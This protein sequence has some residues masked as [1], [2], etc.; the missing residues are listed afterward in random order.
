MKEVDQVIIRTKLTPPVSQ[1]RK[2]VRRHR[3]SPLLSTSDIPR[4]IIVT[5]PAGYGKTSLMYQWFSACRERDT[6]VGWL[7]ADSQDNNA[8]RFLRHLIACLKNNEEKFGDGAMRYLD[9]ARHPDIKHPAGQLIN[10]LAEDDR[11]AFL[12]ID[13][14]HLIENREVDGFLDYLLKLAPPNL[15]LI[16]SSRLVPDLSLPELRLSGELLELDAR[17]LQFD[18]S[19]TFSF[20]DLIN[21]RKLSSSEVELLHERSEGWVAGLQLAAA[22]LANN[23]GKEELGVA[24]NGTLRDIADYLAKAVLQNQNDDVRDFLLRTSLLERFNADLCTFVTGNADSQNIIEWLEQSHLFV[25]PLD[26][27]RTWYRYHH[28]FQDFLQATLK[29]GLPSEIVAL[30][31]RAAS[32][33][34]EHGLGA[35]AVDYALLTGDIQQAAAMAERHAASQILAGYLP[36]TA[37]WLLQLPDVL[38]QKNPMLLSQVTLC[39]WHIFQQEEASQLLSHFEHHLDSFGGALEDHRLKELRNEVRLHRGGI[40]VCASHA[41]ENVL[42]FLD[43]VD[44]SL[45]SG[46]M[47]AV[48]YNIR[49]IALGENNRFSEAL[50]CFRKAARIH[51]TTG[52]PLGVACSYYLEALM[53]LEC[54]NL[55]NIQDMLHQIKKETVFNSQA[56]NYINPSMLESIEGILHYERGDSGKARELLEANLELTKEVGHLKMVS[57]ARTTYA[58][59]LNRQG[60]L[61]GA[62]KELEQLAEI[63]RRNEPGS[64]RAIILAD[65]ERIKLALLNNNPAQAQYIADKYDLALDGPPPEL[66]NHWD[67][68]SCLKALA[69]C[70]AQLVRN[71]PEKAHDLLRRI[72]LFAREVGRTWRYLEARLLEA[73]ALDMLGR[74]FEAADILKP[75]LQIASTDK[76]VNVIRDEGSRVADLIRKLQEQNELIG[77][78]PAFLARILADTSPGPQAVPDG[79]D[80]LEAALRPSDFSEKERIILEQVALGKSNAMIAKRLDLTAHAI[81]WHLGNIFNKLQVRNRAAA[82]SAAKAIRL[83]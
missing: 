13:D 83:I 30:Y 61:P 67:R 51:R 53:H 15:H 28:L 6:R 31:R 32:W 9:A 20:L 65:Y 36:E 10:E 74:D 73:V 45:L 49:G 78:D 34:M 3:L 4:L 42:D 35:E 66:A 64:Y 27:N 21:S 60:D 57:L 70:R 62:H 19:E 50:E 75:I 71:A 29:R 18:K 69:W 68:L 59:I 58:R 48:Y 8:P 44:F 43:Q 12:F 24:F 37:R 80:S 52:S 17:N 77:I 38:K 63:L 39:L 79:E 81:K 54:G 1:K 40:A 23:D 41:P 22:A 56:A 82:V 33:F 46:F 11:D 16:I 7:S 5:A 25:V 2:L 72:S 55:N 26:E 76:M 47:K 14:Y